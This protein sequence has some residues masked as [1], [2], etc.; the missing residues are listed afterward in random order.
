MSAGGGSSGRPEAGFTLLEVAVSGAVLLIFFV[1]V[2][3]VMSS[4]FRAYGEQRTRGA[5][6]LD[7][8][9][10]L[11]RIQEE[12]K[13]AGR[14]TST[15]QEYPSFFIDGDA[16][17]VFNH[18]GHSPPV[19]EAP[20]GTDANGPSREIAYVVP[21]DRDGD[22]YPTQSATGDT[23]WEARSRA[24]LVETAP[25]GVNELLL[26]TRDEGDDDDDDDDDGPGLV[27][28]TVLARR[29]ERA[30]FDDIASDPTLGPTTIRVRLY[31]FARDDAG[32]P[33]EVE[34]ESSIV[35]RNGGRP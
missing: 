28:R 32:G 30:V 24:F 11:A 18:Y 8:A 16:T 25:D 10:A 7:G 33:I 13:E 31:L 29:V 19:H 2:F 4:T 20:A 15:G 9:R 14:V 35:M 21:G 3:G 12:L 22:G 23:E 26:A 6:V 34:L 17:G 5:L 27:T 1:A